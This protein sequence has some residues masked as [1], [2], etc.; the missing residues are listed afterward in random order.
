M[1]WS[2]KLGTFAGIPV[3]VH[4]TFLLLLIWIGASHWIR[5]GNLSAVAMGIAFTSAIFLCVTLH[6]YGH[7]LMARRFGI[8]TKDITLLPIGGLARLER[9]PSEPR[10]E[11]WIALAG[12]AV[13]V[14][15]ATALGLYLLLAGHFEP[16]ARLGV[17]SGNFVE[18]LFVTNVFLVGFNLIPAFPMDG[19]RVLRAALAA[20]WDY[21]RAT[22]TAAG[23]GQALAFVFGLWGL[24]SN[25]FLLFIALFVWIGAAQ[26]AANVEVKSTLTGVPVKDAMIGDFRTISP[27]DDL[28]KA[29]DLI[30]SGWQQDFPV[31][32]KG[33]VVGL[34]TRSDLIAKLASAGLS[35]R[36]REAMSQDF[37]VADPADP[38]EA[39]FLRLQ[40]SE[41]R[42]APILRNGQLLGLLTLDNL[43]EYLLIRA[44]IKA[45]EDGGQ[46]NQLSLPNGSLPV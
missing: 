44:A 23:I 19:G 43:T 17:A 46:V 45:A 22:R 29:V 8:R 2:W 42:T 10:Q 11:L 33:R 30:L 13:N 34:L 15:I 14:A 1:K 7:A 35:A 25:P 41:T 20:R 39:V 27:D 36:I 9:T 37:P 21:V 28:S 3:N 31:V 18:R 5:N 40:E 38:L 24:F 32:A 26:E 6:E 4:T 16:L 12:P